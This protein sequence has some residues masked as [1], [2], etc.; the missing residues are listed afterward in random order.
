MSIDP[1][2]QSSAE[3]TV[4]GAAR[5]QQPDAKAGAAFRA[6]LERLEEKTRGHQEAMSLQCGAHGLKTIAAAMQA[7]RWRHAAACV[8]DYSEATLLG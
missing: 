2:I 7:W 1:R 4:E 8:L 5:T 3:A 6:V